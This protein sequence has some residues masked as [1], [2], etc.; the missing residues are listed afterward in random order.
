MKRLAALA[1]ACLGFTA[2]AAEFP[3]LDEVAKLV[4]EHLTGVTAEQLQAASA[5][6]LL[7]RLGERAR[8]LEDYEEPAGNEPT[9][10]AAEVLEEHFAYLRLAEVGR[11]AVTNVLQRLTELR[12]AGTVTGAV[13]DL[14]FAGGRDFVV[15]ARLAGVFLPPSTP[16]FDWGDGL[17]LSSAPTN[18]FPRPLA[19]LVNAQTRGA[20]EAV[21]AILRHAGAA[22]LIGDTTAG[23]A[24]VVTDVNLST[25]QRLRLTQGRVRLP[26]GQFL[27]AAGVVPDLRLPLD[28]AV[29][30]AFLRDPFTA[31]RSQTNSPTATNSITTVVRVRKRLTEADLVRERE[32]TATDPKATPAAAEPVAA[33][34]V[35][36]PVLARGLDFLKGQTLVR[37]Q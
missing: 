17:H 33:P 20:A 19:V 34:V 32:R 12:A 8:L 15:A 10:A 21:A 27:S 11:D 5:E 18:Q 30:R 29:E 36:D 25:G 35:R 37:T 4:R 13:L 9:V 14:R 1:T 3:P 26:D 6:D 22:L 31:I 7:A 23:D 16:L 28:A 24:A 2:W